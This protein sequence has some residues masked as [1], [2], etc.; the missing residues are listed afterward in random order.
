MKPTCLNKLFPRAR[1]DKSH[2]QIY[3]LRQRLYDAFTIG[4][5]INLPYPHPQNTLPGRR[6]NKV[7]VK[8]LLRYFADLGWEKYAVLRDS[9]DVYA[10]FISP[11]VESDTI[12]ALR[13]DYNL[14]GRGNLQLHL[15]ATSL[16]RLERLKKGE[17]NVQA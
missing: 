16:D 1:G 15:G 11:S 7:Y 6:R 2:L 12:Y 8:Q 10:A 17:S 4:F 13:I 14:D 3:A 5:S 9:R